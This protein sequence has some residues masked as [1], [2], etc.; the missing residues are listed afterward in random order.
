MSNFEEQRRVL[1]SNIAEVIPAE[2]FDERLRASI[3]S[4]RPLR[5]KLG[6]DPGARHVTLGWTVPLRKL[7]QFQDMGHTAVLIVGDFTARVG[8]PSGKSETRKP[9]SVEEVEANAKAVLDQFGLV[10]STENLEVRRNSEWLESMNMADV[11]K[12][13][14]HYTVARMLERDDFAKRFKA[15]T[16]ISM[17]EFLYPLLQG[18]DSVAIES[19]IELGGTD[20]T[21]NNLVGRVLQERYGQRG[22]MVLTMP[23]LIGTDGA[24]VMG[25]SFRNYIG[26]TEPPDEMFGKIMSLVDEA[27]KDYYRLATDLSLSQVEQI[28]EGLD[29]GRLHPAEA[30]RRLA[31]EIVRM[32][33]GEGKAEAAQER[34]DLVHRE[35][36]IPEDVPEFAVEP[37][38]IDGGNVWLP[39]LLVAAGLASSNSDGRRKIE[40]GGVQLDGEPVSSE[41]ASA[42]ELGGRVLQVG[43]RHFVRLFMPV[44]DEK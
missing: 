1:L 29:S 8:D 31:K 17:M 22:Q 32:Y 7:R 28:E 34:F 4:G 13:T 26:V 39:R 14:S 10:L 12:L 33:H 2:E 23:L 18:Y 44:H 5:V 43:R 25:Q 41:E 11:L 27:M 40:Q 38:L 6:L 20:Q 16:P 19:D 42:S 3:E 37:S 9:L 35:R 21:F 15:G 30:K 24:R 36:E